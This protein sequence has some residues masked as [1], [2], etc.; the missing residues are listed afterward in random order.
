MALQALHENKRLTYGRN[1]RRWLAT[2]KGMDA[3]TWEHH[4]LFT[5][6]PSL[7]YSESTRAT[8]TTPLLDKKAAT[9]GMAPFQG[10]ELQHQTSPSEEYLKNY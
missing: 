5:V 1:E 8:E 6:A 4:P 10:N 7:K 2:R 9:A 3:Y